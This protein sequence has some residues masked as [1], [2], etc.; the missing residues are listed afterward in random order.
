MKTRSSNSILTIGLVLF[1]PACTPNN[2]SD[3]DHGPWE[4]R[5][6]IDLG[7][8]VTEDL[9]ERVWGKAF[10]AANGFKRP[11][12]FD[13][14]KWEFEMGGGSVS[15][16]N[17]Y[18][19]L[20]NH[21]GPHV[22]AP[23]HIGVGGGIDSYSIEAFT[24]PLKVFDV[25]HFPKGRSIPADVFNESVRPGDIILIF[26]GYT[27]PQTDNAF[28][29][30][31]TLTRAAAE[32]L[33]SLPVRAFGTDAF[34][35]ANLQ[36]TDAVDAESETARA[37]PIHHSFLSRGI[38]VYE[39]LFNVDQLL[40]KGNM[41]FVGVPLNIREGDGMIVRPVVFVY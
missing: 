20:F 32:Y 7:A 21:G 23:N 8:L 14:I 17:A 16:S 15:G 27:P 9:P 38:P 10:L 3:L 26:T 13:V 31:I 39:Q 36:D 6:V 5:E 37:V 2:Q 18:Y 24:G 30:T 40:D 33:A 4:P 19:T 41:Y 22:D 11:N 35:V 28:P 12:S 34:A 1:L 25:R 29:E